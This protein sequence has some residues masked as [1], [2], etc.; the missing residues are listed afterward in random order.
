MLSLLFN[1][2]Y[3]ECMRKIILLTLFFC[4]AILFNVYSQAKSD[5]FYFGHLPLAK[6]TLLSG[7]KYHSGDQ[8]EWA[9][10][11]YNDN[12][13]E[14][15][16]HEA[17]ITDFIKEHRNQTGWF[18]LKF[19]VADSLRKNHLPWHLMLLVLQKFT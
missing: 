6:D 9:D 15:I 2:L 10:N 13:W 4:L 16:N 5:V 14:G 19:R 12:S 18:R 7:W 3:F 11:S 1:Y 8:A 17:D